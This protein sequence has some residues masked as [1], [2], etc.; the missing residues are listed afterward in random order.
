M[1]GSKVIAWFRHPRTNAP[2]AHG[3]AAQSL[4]EATLPRGGKTVLHRHHLTEEIYHVTAGTG[5]MTL[6]TQSFRVARGDMVLIAPGT[7][8]CIEALGDSVLRILCC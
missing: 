6:E 5:L 8:H 4:A 1:T 3:N 2:K 7:P